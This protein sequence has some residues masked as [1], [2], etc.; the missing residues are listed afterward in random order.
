MWPSLKHIGTCRRIHWFQKCYYFRSTTKNNEVVTEKP[1]QKSGVTRRLAVLILNWRSSSIH[2]SCVV[3]NNDFVDGIT[4]DVSVNT[5]S[6]FCIFHFTFSVPAYLAS[7]LWSG[8]Q[9]SLPDLA[10]QICNKWAWLCVW[11]FSIVRLNYYSNFWFCL[12]ADLTLR[13]SRIWACIWRI[14]PSLKKAL[15]I[16]RKMA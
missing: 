11:S 9:T 3:I 13:A 1:F 10:I 8:N 6:A 15:Q 5:F 4:L 14:C 7:L 2:P 16:Q 12:L